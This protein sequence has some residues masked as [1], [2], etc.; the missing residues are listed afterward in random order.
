MIEAP[1][2]FFLGIRFTA[3]LS[4]TMPAHERKRSRTINRVADPFRRRIAV[5]VTVR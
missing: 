3:D 2:I 5:F 4:A 1:G